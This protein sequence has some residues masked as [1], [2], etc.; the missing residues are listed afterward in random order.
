MA[1]KKR[2][3]GRYK[4]SCRSKGKR[5][6]FYGSSRDEAIAKREQFLSDLEKAP[7]RDDSIT[8]SEWLDEYL[9]D[10]KLRVSRATYT[11][12]ERICRVHLMPV[13]GSVPLVDLQPYH[14]RTLIAQKLEA[15]CSTRSIE[16]MYVI[17]KAALTMAVNEGLLYRNPAAGVRKPKVVKKQA[18]VLTLDQLKILLSAIDDKEYY[19]L[20]YTAVSTGLRRE[21]LLGLRI[22]DININ[23]R[24]LSVNQTVHY[25]NRQTYITKTTKTISSKRVISLDDAT[26][27]Y[28]Q[29]QINEIQYR[30]QSV[31]RYKRE[32]D[33][34][35]PAKDGGPIYPAYVS[36]KLKEYVEKAGLPTSFTFHGLRHTHATLLLESGANYKS[37]QLRLG[38]SSFKT[39]MDIYS[40]ITQKMEDELLEKIPKI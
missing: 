37:V 6:Y 32:L 33:L 18:T 14:V 7:N 30:R 3:D 10:A 9:L 5:Y 24:M 4:T 27:Q 39:T 34:L 16:Y 8:L 21:E 38:H 26:Y 25:D 1:L 13:L 35:F 23:R 12:Y 2:Q 20:I 22:Q 17:L 19:R 36:A 15:K 29:D 11:S 40:H 31:F 28:I